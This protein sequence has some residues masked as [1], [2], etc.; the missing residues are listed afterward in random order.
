MKY[1]GYIGKGKSPMKKQAER[2]LEPTKLHAD[3]SKKHLSVLDAQRQY[4]ADKAKDSIMFG[5]N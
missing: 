4:S 2:Q 1:K 3:E 5:G